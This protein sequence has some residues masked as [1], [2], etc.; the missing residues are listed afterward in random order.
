MQVGISNQACSDDTIERYK[1]QLVAKWF[2]EVEGLDYS[3]SFA[4]M[5]KMNY[6]RLVLSIVVSR[7]W[8]VHQ[9]D[10]KCAF[11]HGNLQ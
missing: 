10:V 5:A 11:P 4:P 2:L 8:T 6:V 1:P 7:K 3:E 9:M